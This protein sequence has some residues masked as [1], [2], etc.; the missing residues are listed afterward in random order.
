MLAIVEAL[1]VGVYVASTWGLTGS[2]LR[3]SGFGMGLFE[4]LS[5]SRSLLIRV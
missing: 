4:T 3:F 5:P 2:S 1:V